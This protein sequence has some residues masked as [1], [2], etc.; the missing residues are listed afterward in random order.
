MIKNIFLILFVVITLVLGTTT[1]VFGYLYSTKNNEY[2]KLL[3]QS[4]DK[5]SDTV[6]IEEDTK[7]PD[8]IIN[9]SDKSLEIDLDYPSSWTLTL[10][11]KIS[12]DFAYEPVYGRIIEQYEAT[13]KKGGAALVFEKILG[14]VDGFPNKI[15]KSQ[16]DFIEVSSKLARYKLTSESEWQYV[17]LLTCSDYNELFDSP[18]EVGEICVTN[19]YNGFGVYANTA[20]VSGGDITE[21]EE[22]DQ[23]VISALN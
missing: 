23:I 5:S 20:R 6:I 16:V 8:I 22:S 19:F 3:T 1:G 9:F 11:T 14:A 17:Q 21:L 10:D 7:V 4:L 15:K 18:A 12:D 13:L 2:N